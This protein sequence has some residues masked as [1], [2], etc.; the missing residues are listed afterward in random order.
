MAI[1]IRRDENSDEQQPRIPQNPRQPRRGGGGGGMLTMLLPMLLSMFRKSPKLAL[2]LLIGGGIFYFMGGLGGG[3]SN[4]DIVSPYQESLG[5]THNPEKYGNTSVYEPL[6][7]NRKNPL[8][9]KVSLLEYAPK[10]L[11]QGRQ[12]SCVGWSSAYAARTI[13]HS[14]Q[15][16]NRADDLPFSPSYLYNQ[17]ALSGCNGTYLPDALEVM[18][19]GGSLPFQYFPYDESSCSQ[20]PNSREKQAASQFKIKDY[21]R[22]TTG[23]SSSQKPNMLAIKQ[24]LAAGAPV[25]I[26]MMVG[27]SFMRAMEGREVWMPNQSDYQQ[28]GFGGHAMCVIGYDDYKNGGSFEIMNSWGE[29]WGKDGVGWVRYADFHHFTKEAYGLYPMGSAETQNSIFAMNF[30][31]VKN[32]GK[33]EVAFRESGKNT[34]RT[35]TPMKKGEDF[36]IAVENT[37]ECYIYV[38]GQEAT[39]EIYTL[40]PYDKKHSPYCGVKGLRL[41][42]RDASL[43]PDDTGGLD[44][45]GVIVTKEPI[46][47]V[48]AAK[49]LNQASGSMGQKMEQILGNNVMA[50]MQFEAGKTIQ[51]GSRDTRGNAAYIVMEIDKE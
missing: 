36:K 1:R 5:F 44:Y 41:F 22:L 28:R 4:E 2:L 17:V 9:E 12:G 33:V 31:L 20:K 8:P 38:F 30:G 47:Y 43:Y 37:I 3:G 26:G 39:G 49:A 34:F 19:K 40:F 35:V 6:A 45:M 10:R 23:R 29:R 25:L 13:L 50:N 14:R 48:A 42:P 7:D 46:D 27:G 32:K 24:N 18:K 51:F 11:N 15:T 21:Q 16:G